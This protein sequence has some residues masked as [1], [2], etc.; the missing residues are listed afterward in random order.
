MIEPPLLRGGLFGAAPNGLRRNSALLGA[1]FFGGPKGGK[2]NRRRRF[3][4]KR[5]IAIERALIQRGPA[6]V[7]LRRRRGCVNRRSP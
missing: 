1:G 2:R 5:F 3:G 7:G 4:K 6:R